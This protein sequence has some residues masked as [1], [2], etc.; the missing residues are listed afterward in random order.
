[1]IASQPC[2]ADP[3]WQAITLNVHDV[4][5]DEALAEVDVHVLNLPARHRDG[6]LQ[7]HAS[8]WQS[9]HEQTPYCEPGSDALLKWELR[10]LVEPFEVWINGEQQGF[11][12]VW[13]WN[14]ETSAEGYAWVPCIDRTGFQVHAISVVDGSPTPQWVK[15]PIVLEAVAEHPSGR[16]WSE[17]RDSE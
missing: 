13:K 9:E 4:A 1:M 10:G 5:P 3:G 11:V 12:Q 15:I 8:A 2:A 14:D 17:L 7:I 6:T 16:S